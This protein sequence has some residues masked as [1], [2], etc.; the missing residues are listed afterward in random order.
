MPAGHT[1]SSV[2]YQNGNWV[3]PRLSERIGNAAAGG[4]PTKGAWIIVTGEPCMMCAKLI[5]LSFNGVSLWGGYKG[6][7]T[8]DTSLIMA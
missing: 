4:V 5:Q 1:A 2:R 6:V 3:S 7:T 8:S